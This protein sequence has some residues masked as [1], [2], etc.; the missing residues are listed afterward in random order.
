LSPDG[1]RLAIG[2]V[3]SIWMHVRRDGTE[4]GRIY[5]WDTT[6]GSLLDKH[7][8]PERTLYQPR[9]CDGA[10]QLQVLVEK[11]AHSHAGGPA[12]FSNW[13]VSPWDRLELTPIPEFSREG[14]SGRFIVT[15][16]NGREIE[17]RTEDG[18][19]RSTFRPGPDGSMVEEMLFLDNH[20]EIG[21]TWR[22]SRTAPGWLAWLDRQLGTSWATRYS[23]TSGVAIYD[24]QQQRVV[25]RSPGQEVVFG[26]KHAAILS[27]DRRGSRVEIWDLPMSEHK[28][29]PA[30]LAGI[31]AGLLT[32]FY[33]L[34]KN[35][36]R[37]LM[38]AA[39][40]LLV[41]SGC[42]GGAPPPRART[43]VPMNQL[44]DLENAIVLRTD[45]SDQAAWE[46]I[47]AEIRKPL[48]GFHADVDFVDDRAY[49]EITKE[50]LLSLFKG[51]DHPFVIV[52]D[53]TAIS[54]AE[55]PLL[56]IDLEGG[57]GRQFR[58]IPSQIQGI[59][60]NLSIANMDFEDF[61]GAVDKDGVF[62]GFR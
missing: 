37:L 61:A 54:N 7:D 35:P 34:L 56:V 62:R 33:G 51:S 22:R 39:A 24:Q 25:H 27:G 9:V 57:A 13:E 2:E 20:N 11:F 21:C 6:T 42:G 29:C 43:G 40:L 5:L 55:H 30:W 58:A 14:P 18:S 52:V 48:G 50:R 8:A 4:T 46:A 10:T 16:P 49:A 26:G 47:C 45:F 3:S 12:H 60:N 44:K 19:R 31:V 59:E 17:V 28:S 15:S 38:C 41:A 36:A 1:R 53:R 32:L 23:V